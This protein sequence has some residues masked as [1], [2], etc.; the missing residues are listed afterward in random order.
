MSIYGS[1]FWRDM[2]DRRDGERDSERYDRED[3]FRSRYDGKSDAYF[4]GYDS[5]E[6]EARRR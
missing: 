2:D 6:R 5:A 1:S 3:P 4:N